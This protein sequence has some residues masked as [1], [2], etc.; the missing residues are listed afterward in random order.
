[1]I[2]SMATMGTHTSLSRINYKHALR[3]HEHFDDD[4]PLTEVTGSLELDAPDPEPR[5]RHRSCRR[6]ATSWEYQLTDARPIQAAVSAMAV[7]AGLTR[8][9]LSATSQKL[10]SPFAFETGTAVT[11]NVAKLP[12][13]V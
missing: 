8:G 4:A 1:L 5:C 13:A 9:I 3:F 6:L 7:P 12:V 10:R 11:R 2:V